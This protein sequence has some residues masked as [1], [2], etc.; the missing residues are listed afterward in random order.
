MP[1]RPPDVNPPLQIP[2]PFGH[3][4]IAGDRLVCRLPRREVVVSAP[5]RLLAEV[6]AACDGVRRWSEVMQTLAARW[7]RRQLAAFLRG[8]AAQQ[9]LVEAGELWAHW[10]ALAQLPQAPVATGAQLAELPTRSQARLLPGEGPWLDEVRSCSNPIAAV[11]QHRES[12]RTF[13]DRPIPHEALCSILWAAH[14]VT[15]PAASGALRWHRSCGSGG[16]M[17]SARWIV[18]V[19]RELPPQQP[20]GTGL[21]AGLHEARFHTAGGVSFERIAGPQHHAWRCLGDPRVLRYASALVLPVLDIAVPARKYGNR[22]TLFALI[23]AGQS[24][25]NAQLMAT[26]LRVASMLRGDTVAGRVLEIPALRAEQGAHWLAVP[27][28]VLGAWPS[29]EEREAQAADALLQV[30]HNLQVP[31]STG[32]AFAARR[33]HPGDATGASGITGATG[34]ARANHAMPAGSG[35]SADPAL[36]LTKAEAEAWERIAWSTASRVFEARA[37]ELRDLLHPELLVAYSPRQYASARFP[38]K[39]FSP[40]RISL[41]TEA[42]DCESGQARAV[43]ADGVFAFDALPARHRQHACTNASTSG[44]AAGT[45]IDDALMRAALELIERDALVCAWLAGAAPARV[46]PASLPADAQRRIEA[47]QGQG[48][49]LAVLDLQ[50]PWCVVL[51][52]FAQSQAMPFTALTAAA[53]FGREEALAKALDE[54]EGRFAHAACFPVQAGSADPMRAIERYY[55]DPRTYRRSDFFAQAPRA[56]RFGSVGRAG[57]RDWPGLRSRLHR[58]GLRLHAVDLTPDAA[59]VEQGRSR[60]HVVRALVPGLVPIWFHRGVQPQGMPRFKQ[61]AA[62]RGARPA[63]HYIHPFT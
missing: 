49:Q 53:A 13:A 12:L 2:A 40:R 45:S 31:D 19:L 38:F 35:R 55:R 63:G 43:L 58:Q 8:L 28:M 57:A 26:S 17:H 61:F 46:E 3:W 4:L 24:L 21:A 54:A 10:G 27:G 41:W 39:P 33:P 62:V 44:V 25:Q 14:G 20:S 11:L 5:G 32:F 23:E 59:S 36:A 60:L 50:S 16:N 48:L 42:R 9:V 34:A 22:A 52:V 29:D 18:A 6:A 30:S 56:L 51:A 1:H 15:R 37:G 47:L 7:P